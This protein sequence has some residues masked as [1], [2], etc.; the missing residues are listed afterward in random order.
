MEKSVLQGWL[1]GKIG[2]WNIEYERPSSSSVGTKIWAKIPSLRRSTLDFYF[3]NFFLSYFTFA[4]KELYIF[5][6]SL[7]S[8]R[9]GPKTSSAMLPCRDALSLKDCEGSGCQRTAPS[10]KGHHLGLVLTAGAHQDGVAIKHVL[11]ESS[12]P[13]EGLLKVDHRSVR[14]NFLCWEVNND[15]LYL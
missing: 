12:D 10:I 3:V 15:V 4:S 9:L 2:T 8:K 7:I 13:S 6:S 14:S 11:G 1:K 5:S